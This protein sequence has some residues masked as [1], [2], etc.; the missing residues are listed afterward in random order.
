MITPDDP[1]AHLKGRL[2]TQ[3]GDYAV[4]VAEILAAKGPRI[5]T[6]KPSDTIATLCECLRE[7]RIGAAVV[8]SN[9]M[10]ADGV[11]SERDV[12]FGLAVH[13]AKLH[14]LPVS[15]LMTKTVIT[16]SPSD[17]VALVASTMLARN[18]RHLPVVEHGRVVGMISIRD[19][20]NWRVSELQHQTGLL[21]AFVSEA[22]R[23][24]PVDR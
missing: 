1:R 16:C 22:E 15:E 13:K 24:P 2:E 11:I 5:I 8:S 3:M 12:A 23:N 18:I 9:G 10:T 14:G 21:N 7:K 20:L 6:I 19:V 4:T 17:T